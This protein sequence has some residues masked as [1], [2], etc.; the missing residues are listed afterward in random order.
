MPVWCLRREGRTRA[1]AVPGV[2]VP[3]RP[4]RQPGE[5]DGADPRGHGHARLPLAWPRA[6]GGRADSSPAVTR[7][8]VPRGATRAYAGHARGPSDNSLAPSPVPGTIPKV[9]V[10]Q[11]GRVNEVVRTTRRPVRPRSRDAGRWPRSRGLN[12]RR[13]DTGS[14]VA[15]HRSRPAPPYP[16]HRDGSCN[17]GDVA[18]S[19]ERL[20]RNQQ[21][22]GS[23][24]AISTT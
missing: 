6:A 11:P 1:A 3:V 9:E 15:T 18:Q 8:P 22:A 21:V 13:S 2:A 14:V 16:Q 4:C 7:I 20:V 17:S 10:T 5:S 24:P 12:G 19:G 23:S